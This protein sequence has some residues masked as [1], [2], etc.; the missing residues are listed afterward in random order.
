MAEIS[1]TLSKDNQI[2]MTNIT[3]RNHSNSRVVGLYFKAMGKYCAP[4]FIVST[5]LHTYKAVF[6]DGLF[7][8]KDSRSANTFNSRWSVPE[9]F[10]GYLH[11]I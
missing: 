1:P 4:L 6:S 10:G 5:L 3:G 2:I 7:K 9:Q 8:N 11:I